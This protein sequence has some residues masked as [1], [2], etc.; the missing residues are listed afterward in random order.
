MNIITYNH[1]LKII[2]LFTCNF[3]RTSYCLPCVDF[4]SCILEFALLFIEKKGMLQYRLNESFIATATTI[5]N[6]FG[7]FSQYQIT[8]TTVPDGILESQTIG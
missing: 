7:N 3:K 1:I 6:N 4:E 8:I 2:L 5:H